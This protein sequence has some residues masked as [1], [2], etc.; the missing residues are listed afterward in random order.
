VAVHGDEVEGASWWG[1][2]KGAVRKRWEPIGGVL[3]WGL[4]IYG[5]TIDEYV[6]SSV[7]FFFL[8]ESV[9]FVA[10]SLAKLVRGKVSL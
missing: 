10:Q 8:V 6:V 7:F 9:R 4:E 3:R 5:E 1:C 2:D